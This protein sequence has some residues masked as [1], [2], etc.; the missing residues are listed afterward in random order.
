MV[1]YSVSYFA[2]SRT[3]C[4]SSKCF[5]QKTIWRDGGVRGEVKG[6]G[7]VERGEGN[8]EAIYMHMCILYVFHTH[9]CKRIRCTYAEFTCTVFSNL[10]PSCAHVMI[11]TELYYNYCLCTHN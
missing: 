2:L 11:T 10:H 3:H 4:K 1:Y 6:I 5:A 8:T 7:W 9:W